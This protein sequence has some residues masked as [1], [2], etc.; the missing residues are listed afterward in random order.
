MTWIQRSHWTRKTGSSFLLLFPQPLRVTQNPLWSWS[1]LGT[2][3]IHSMIPNPLF[4]PL[5]A[6]CMTSD[7]HRMYTRRHALHFALSLPSPVFE[8]TEKLD[9][10]LIACFT[11][12][13][14]V[15]VEQFETTSLADSFAFLF[16][17]FFWTQT[18]AIWHKN[19]DRSTLSHVSLFVLIMNVHV[20][21]FY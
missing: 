14:S 17:S 13:N 19:P 18:C 1:S 5:A 15:D 10:L 6:F 2:N 8:E 21:R 20:C 11:N 9:L 7:T 4:S 16:S 3:I 12:K